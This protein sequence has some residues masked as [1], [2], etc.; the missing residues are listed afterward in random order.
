MALRHGF[1]KL[2]LR[3]IVSI[4]APANAASLRVA[5]K[6]GLTHERTEGHPRTG[7]ALEVHAIT[8]ERWQTLNQ[9]SRGSDP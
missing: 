1:G 7:H 4:M 5:E 8:R 9:P 6:L 2:G 3:R